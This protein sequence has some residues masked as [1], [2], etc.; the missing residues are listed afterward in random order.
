[1]LWIRWQD[2]FVIFMSSELDVL[3]SIGAGGHEM[4]NIT[5]TAADTQRWKWIETRVA[6]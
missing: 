1:M 4:K 5:T 6:S 3:N 2:R